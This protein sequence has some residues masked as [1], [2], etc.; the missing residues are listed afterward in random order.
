MKEKILSQMVQQF[1]AKHSRLPAHILIDPL[2]LVVLSK[3]RSVAPTW[4]GI[5]VECREVKPVPAKGT[6]D[7]LGVCLWEDTL[8]SVDVVYNL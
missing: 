2:A 6:V 3:R 4:N 8:R 5:P 1:R 7:A